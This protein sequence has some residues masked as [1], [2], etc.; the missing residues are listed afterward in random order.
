MDPTPE[1]AAALAVE[2]HDC[3]TCGVS[4][5][6]ACRTRGGNTASR[7][8]T[9]RFVPVPTLGNAAEILVPADRG[10][11]RPWS[12]G[13]SAGSTRAHQPTVS[14]LRI[15]YAYCSTS[16]TQGLDS[17]FDALTAARCE[18][19]FSERVSPSVKRRPELEAALRLAGERRRAA[20]T[21]PVIVTA[22][23]LGRFAR[24]S[25]ELIA[26]CA[27][28]QSEGVALE[29][30]SGSLTGLFDPQGTGSMFFTALAA[31]AALDRD[32]VRDKRLEG[33]R[34][35]AAK[36]RVSGRPRVFDQDTLALVRELRDQGVPVP[37][38]AERVTITAGKNAG[39]HPSLASVYR[40][41]ADSESESSGQ[42]SP[43][44]DPHISVH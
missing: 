23:E 22:T 18:R 24:N 17:Q 41:L 25:G 36:G 37:E 2:N 3:P 27:A 1:Y 14:P 44:A 32:H 43:A 29:L 21:R 35:A 38:I 10:P 15:G 31:A 12:P 6:S 39:R 33:Q 4:A 7:Y 40:A 8:H 34:T 26:L 19:I 11:G 42:T 28:L 30:L 5:G 13:P 20:P 16:A 9:A